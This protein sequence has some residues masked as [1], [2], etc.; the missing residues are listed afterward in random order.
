[1]HHLTTS[2]DVASTHGTSLNDVLQRLQ[3][4]ATPVSAKI[5][6]SRGTVIVL[7][8]HADDQGVGAE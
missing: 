4:T 2:D 6:P 5:T 8:A 1:M 7:M 3:Q